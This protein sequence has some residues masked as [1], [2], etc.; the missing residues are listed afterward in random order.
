[1]SAVVCHKPADAK[2][3]PILMPCPFCGSTP[4][5]N[6]FTEGAGAPEIDGAWWSIGCG[7]KQCTAHPMAFGDT[8]PEARCNWNTR[9]MCRIGECEFRDGA[10]RT[11]QPIIAADDG[12]VR[13][14]QNA[15]VEFLLRNGGYD[16]NDLA[17]MSFTDDDR[18][19]FAQLIGYS[20][21][22]WGE[23][24][25]V[26]I[27]VAHVADAVGDLVAASV[28]RPAPSTLRRKGGAS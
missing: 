11:L 7:S 28:D 2:R 17:R 3:R 13:F 15:I 4:K 24:S 27:E 8:K 23:L 22:G 10:R 25:Y 6:Y 12:V 19:Q 18:A 26:P 1:M 16:M 5:F 21:C 9:V 20:V 14:K